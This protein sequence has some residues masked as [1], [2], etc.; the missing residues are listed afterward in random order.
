MK[1][2]RKIS[3]AAALIL[4][5]GSPAAALPQMTASAAEAAAVSAAAT[6]VSGSVS[7]NFTTQGTQSDYFT[8][9]GNLSTGKGTSNYNGMT[10]TQCL[11]MESAT[12][13]TFSTAGNAQMMLAIQ[14]GESIYIDSQKY[15]ISG[16]TSLTVSLGAGNHEIRKGSG[17]SNLF[18]IDIKGDG[19]APVVT[20][21]PQQG[22]EPQNTQATQNT[23]SPVSS[24]NIKAVKSGGWNEMMYAVFSGIQDADVTAVS[25][26][27]KATGALTG[28]D[29]QYL[30]RDTQQG[31]RVDIPGVPAGSYTLH[32][33]TKK[34]AVDIRD[35]QVGAQDRSGYAHF[36]YNAGVGAYT[37]AG[38]L[39]ANA[40]VLYV[41]NSNKDTVTVKSKDGTT[42]SGIGNIL[43]SAGKES[44]GGKTAK[45][46]TANSNK[47]IIEKLAKDGTPL[48]VRIIGD[49]KAPAGLTAYDSDNYGGSVG[50]NGFM[51]R[52]QSGKDVTI[53]G[54]GNDACINGWGIHFICE[55]GNPNLGKSFEVRNIAFRN[56][57][58]DCIGMEGVQSGDALTASVERC[59]IHN[60]E[61]YAP[62]I[63]NPAESDK[64]GGDGACDFK[65]GMYFTNSYNY[66]EGYHKTNLVGASDSNL[67]FHITFHHNYWK[68][69]ESRGPLAR[70]ANI[71]MYNNV[72]EGQTSYC[73]NPRANAY[74]FSEY[75]L[76]ESCKNPQQVKLGAIKS[77]HDTLTNCKG[78]MQAVTVTNKSQKVQSANK[79]GEFD[80]NGS[81]S[82][83][84][85]NSYQLLTDTSKLKSYFAS[86]GGTLNDTN[87][88]G[89]ASAADT[90]PPAT[91][92]TT[93]TTTAETTT[94]TEETTTVT[95]T[96]T[97]AETTTVTASETTPAASSETT[98]ETTVSTVSEEPKAG[99]R[100]DV[101]CSGAVDV[102]DA[103]ILARL[104][105]EDAGVNITAQGRANADCNQNGMP[106]SEDVIL[107]LQYIVHIIEKL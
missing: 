94:T 25:Y 95:T 44:S 55:S 88:S 61:F 85:S 43:N 84:P 36:N 100:G 99:L 46:G 2:Y 12:S 8:I 26:S 32:M 21:Q 76:F 58:E 40:V 9:T 57:P 7:H 72:F 74:I 105:A 39:K 22:S 80:T 106:D 65:R 50:D 75:N 89:T 51:A 4:S 38:T 98:T 30:V 92:T 91:T 78:D 54:I 5:V 29:L 20:T 69:C 79:Y 86:N 31:V 15:D 104:V 41:T 62:K 11:K 63:S 34:G 103:V 1:A 33:E 18:Y 87:Q 13:I 70:Q 68:N 27:G 73:Q 52:M 24:G 107:I 64:A 77:F 71:H 14:D 10:L 45:G 47:G 96:V 67:Q 48:V 59:W 35:I 49:V 81:Q 60:N 66:Y 56:V 93:T 28:D 42:V 37:D 90:Q 102:S 97:A 17:S 16:K 83:I 3:I 23:G 101:N 53:E 19:S 82:Y 6:P